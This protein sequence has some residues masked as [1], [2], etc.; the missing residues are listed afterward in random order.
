M[1]QRSNDKLPSPLN[2]ICNITL[3]PSSR[4]SSKGVA[5][6]TQYTVQQPQSDAPFAS[7]EHTAAAPTTVQ[8]A[9]HRTYTVARIAGR[10][11]TE[12]ADILEE[13][14]RWTWM[15]I[16]KELRST[17]TCCAAAALVKSD[18]ERLLSCHPISLCYH[19]STCPCW[20]PSREHLSFAALLTS[21]TAPRCR[22]ANLSA[23]AA[24]PVA[25]LLVVSLVAL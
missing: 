11:G 6:S 21:V 19:T 7:A 5:H 15:I 18:R 4:H 14:I 23:D 8:M 17:S 22:T 12:A 25:L 9:Q 10:A 1:Q 20:L 16:E 2:K 24:A 3:R 13:Q